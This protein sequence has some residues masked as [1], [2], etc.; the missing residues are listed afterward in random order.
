MCWASSR[1][2]SMPRW[3]PFISP[4]QAVGCGVSRAT[5]CPRRSRRKC[6]VLATASP[7]GCEGKPR[8]C[9]AR[10]SR[11]VP[12]GQLECRAGKARASPDRSRELQRDGRGGDRVGIL[13]DVA[14]F[15]RGAPAAGPASRSA[16]PCARR[17]TAPSSRSCWRRRNG[18]RKSCRPSRRNCGSPTRSSP[19]RARSSRSPRGRLEAQ[20]AELEQTNSQLEE[21]AT[22]LESQRDELTRG[23][24]CADR[25]C[26]G[27]HPLQSIQVGIPRQHEPRAAHAA[28]LL[29]HPREAARGQQAGQPHR[30]AGEVRADHFRGG[31]RPARAHQRHPGS[32]EDRGR[33]D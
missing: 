6:S 13:P 25:A 17:R 26:R 14:A 21:Q 12:A 32:V 24:E 15:G 27:S 1:V 18:S 4:S 8:R 23:A 3:V 11:R 29:A 31:Q 2:I 7:A 16:S 33:Q 30:G 19:S 9:R 10:L 20:Q 28:Q 5:R 22:A